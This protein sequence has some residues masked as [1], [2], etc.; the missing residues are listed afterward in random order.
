MFE[1]SVKSIVEEVRCV[2]FMRM[3]VDHKFR[4]SE[5]TI[6]VI[7]R[8]RIDKATFAK[9]KRGK[10]KNVI[11]ISNFTIMITNAEPL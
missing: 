10:I 3:K 11:L 1:Q 5:R 4:L 6:I 2:E 8:I 7:T 9:G